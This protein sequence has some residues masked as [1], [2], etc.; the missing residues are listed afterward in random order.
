MNPLREWRMLY[1]KA[2]KG[3]RE[4]SRVYFYL[5]L[6]AFRGTGILLREERS[7]SSH[8]DLFRIMLYP[9]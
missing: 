7:F 3:Q 1:K 6:C 5:P 9:S 4:G 8:G 2:A